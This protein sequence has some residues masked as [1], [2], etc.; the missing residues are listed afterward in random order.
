MARKKISRQ[1][2]DYH[3]NDLLSRG[4]Y[5]LA[6]T[7]YT[8]PEIREIIGNSFDQFS[9]SFLDRSYRARKKVYDKIVSVISEI[10]LLNDNGNNL[11]N[12]KRSKI[13]ERE[14]K[15]AQ[16]TQQT[17]PNRRFRIKRK[18]KP[19]GDNYFLISTTYSTREVL[20]YVYV[21]SE[22]G[23][24]KS[25]TIQPDT[26]FH[27]SSFTESSKQGARPYL[28]DLYNDLKTKDSGLYTIRFDVYVSS[29]YKK[30][31]IKAYAQ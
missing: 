4:A 5:S 25:A 28:S 22:G 15:Y 17:N 2:V 11:S 9:G 12:K 20:D 16:K 3:A 19:P 14:S 31:I 10:R 27:I 24:F 29:V 23:A 21:V 8:G 26:G 7:N 13:F 30:I 6:Y 1:F 18:K